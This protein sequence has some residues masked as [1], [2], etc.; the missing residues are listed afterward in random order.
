MFLYLECSLIREDMHS[1][2]LPL[3]NALIISLYTIRHF[4]RPHLGLTG[5]FIGNVIDAI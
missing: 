1:S 3:T 2:I 4:V 5:S